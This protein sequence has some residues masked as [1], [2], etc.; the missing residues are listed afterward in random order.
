M[1]AKIG[2]K[3]GVLVEEGEGKSGKRRE[4]MGMV[5]VI[6]CWRDF[7]S[8]R[9]VLDE[10]W[11][12][13]FREYES[14]VSGE[15]GGE[16]WRDEENEQPAQDW[17][18]GGI[19]R[20]FEGIEGYAGEGEETEGDLKWALEEFMGRKLKILLGWELKDGKILEVKFW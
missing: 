9:S 8:C 5:I 7:G 6:S 20:A 12:A 15:D 2:M 14:L 3:D 18:L 16:R 10:R 4:K 17:E 11:R 1:E 19:K 13:H